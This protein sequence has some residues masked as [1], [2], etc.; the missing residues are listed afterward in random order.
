MNSGKFRACVD[1]EGSAYTDRTPS[2]RQA[3]PRGDRCGYRYRHSGVFIQKRAGHPRAVEHRLPHSAGKSCAY[4][5]P[6]KSHSPRKKDVN[7]NFV[8]LMK[9]LLPSGIYHAIATHDPKMIEATTQ[10][11]RRPG[12]HQG[13]I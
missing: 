6:R 12:H 11:R 2:N 9:I 7:A 4:K 3:G 1:M 8:K 5:E 10:V 13:Q